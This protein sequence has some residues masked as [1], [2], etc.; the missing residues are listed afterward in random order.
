MGFEACF[1]KMCVIHFVLGGLVLIAGTGSNCHLVNPNGEDFR[2]GG[3]GHAIGDEGS[4]EFL[5][6]LPADD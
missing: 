3:Y 2:C 4:G 5:T 1:C 6:C